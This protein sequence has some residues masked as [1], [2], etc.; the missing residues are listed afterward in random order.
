MKNIYSYVKWILQVR[1]MNVISA[2]VS[3]ME[4]PHM[5]EARQVEMEQWV[6]DF[7]DEKRKD[8][9]MTVEE[10]A[11]KVYPDIPPSAARMRL[12]GLRVAQA[13]NKKRKRLLYSEF[14]QMSRALGISPSEVSTLASQAFAE[15]SI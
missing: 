13:A 7:L 8:Q 3:Q 5:N 9:G 1:D 14:V 12:Q 6:I 2:T 10:W 4:A 11:V 15:T